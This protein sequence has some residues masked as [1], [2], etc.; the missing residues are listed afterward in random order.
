[1]RGLLENFQSSYLYIPASRCELSRDFRR[2]HWL[3]CTHFAY[4]VKYKVILIDWLG[5][6]LVT[7]ITD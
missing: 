6:L 2:A 4:M 7:I 3:R 1:M 5:K